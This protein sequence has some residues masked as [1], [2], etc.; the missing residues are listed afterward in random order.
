MW[1]KATSS[2]WTV[3]PTAPAGLLT[4]RML[5]KARTFEPEFTAF[6]VVPS[7]F[8]PTTNDGMTLMIANLGFSCSMN[9]SVL[10]YAMIFDA[11]YAPMVLAYGPLGDF[12][13]F[14]GL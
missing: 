13:L 12:T 14:S 11:A 1:T 5:R 4:P 2:T 9:S 8:L 6:L 7:S 10:L 3:V